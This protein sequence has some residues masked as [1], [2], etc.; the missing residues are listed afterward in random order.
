MN[1]ITRRNLVRLFGSGAAAAAMAPFVPRSSHAGGNASPRR[2]LVIYHGL[3]Y[4]EN[5]FWPTAGPSGAADDFTL[6]ATQSVLEPYREHLIYPDGLTLYGA[7]YYFPDDDNEHG[8]GGSMTFTGSLKQG[9]AT[10]PSFEQLIADQWWEQ[11]NTPFRHVG[12]GVRGDASE[13][14]ACFFRGDQQ[15]IVPQNSAV[16]AFDSLFAALPKDQ[17]DP[18]AINR[19]R[20]Q[21][22]SVIDV[23]RSELT[24]VRDRIGTQER[25]ILDQHL[26]HLRS[27]EDRVVEF[28]NACSVP[29]EPE[30]FSDDAAAIEA[31]MDMIANAFACDLTGVMTLQL[32]IADGRITMFDGV[33]AHETTHATGDTGGAAEVLATHRDIDAWWADRWLYLLQRLDSITE[34]DGTLLDNTLVVWGTDT[35]TGQSY[36]L[37]A[38]RHWRMPYF[39]AGG[40]NWAFPTGRYLQIDHPD[41]IDS[42][43]FAQWQS[44]SRLYTSILQRAGIDVD[45]FGNMDIGSGTLPGL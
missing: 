40:R 35:T 33:N 30:D 4:L 10:G 5:S 13:H 42:E 18:A 25:Y 32:G 21:R 17:T 20:A 41:G 24:G 36:S 11:R 38:H 29:E 28:D 6:G 43:S 44:N 39:M 22:R 23:V 37:G 26:E 14:N 2:L 45:T 27:L 3:G 1:G 12:L 34:A 15:P 7:P 19:L 9:Y 16:A 31:Q 8:S